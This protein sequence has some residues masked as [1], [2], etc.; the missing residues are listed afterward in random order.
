MLK[1]ARG[2]MY[3]WVTHVGKNYVGGQCPHGCIYCY[4]KAMKKKYPVLKK[5]YS[6]KLYLIEK[7]FTENLGKGKTIFIQNCGDLFA[8][9]VPKEWIIRVLKHCCQYPENKYLFQ[10]KNPTRFREF[11]D[12][13]PPKTI[14]GTTI[15]T[16]RENLHVSKA[17]D[18]NQRVVAMIKIKSLKEIFPCETMVNIEPVLDFDLDKMINIFICMEPN[19]ISI[20]ADSKAK[21]HQPIEKPSYEKA[22]LLIKELKK[23]S[24]VKIKSNL[25]LLAPKGSISSGIPA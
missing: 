10:T 9:A 20:G 1:L 5:I 22:L 24:K 12:Y 15:E 21:Y 16:N 8:E 7:E 19:F 11:I 23:F 14:L 13:F 2:N 17:P 3:S 25:K 18:I 6:G 4:M